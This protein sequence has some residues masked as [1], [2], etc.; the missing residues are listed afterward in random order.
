MA[1]LLSIGVAGH[2]IPLDPALL[3]TG[4]PFDFRLIRTS[5]YDIMKPAHLSDMFANMFSQLVSSIADVKKADEVQISDS[6]K[7][8][9]LPKPPKGVYWAS[10]KS[11]MGDYYDLFYK[12][13]DLLSS[14]EQFENGEENNIEA[15]GVETR[16]NFDDFKNVFGNP[17]VL[18]KVNGNKTVFWFIQNTFSLHTVFKNY[19]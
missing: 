18:P 19:T 4:S 14:T 10:Q 7:T 9:P 17:T 2:D 5:F 3:I 15:N 16:F 11:E 8:N 12:E 6:I 13:D 1:S